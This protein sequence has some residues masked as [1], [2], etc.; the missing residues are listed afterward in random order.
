MLE[1]STYIRFGRAVSI[2]PLP[3]T[4]AAIRKLSLVFRGCERPHWV[5][6]TYPLNGNAAIQGHERLKGSLLPNYCPIPNNWPTA[7][8]AEPL[9]VDAMWDATGSRLT[10]L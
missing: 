5:G 4:A 10:S 8:L 3:V 9:P 2:H 6:S 7:G 1:D